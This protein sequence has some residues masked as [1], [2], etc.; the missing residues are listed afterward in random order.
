MCDSKCSQFEDM[1]TINK[2]FKNHINK[3]TEEVDRR[4]IENFTNVCKLF[5]CNL[6]SSESGFEGSIR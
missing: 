6:Y 5:E 4:D 3:H 1:F 2:H